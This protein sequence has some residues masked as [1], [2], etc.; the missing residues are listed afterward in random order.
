MKP[1]PIPGDVLASFDAAVLLI[2]DLTAEAVKIKDKYGSTSKL[3]ETKVAQ[4]ETI[5]TLYNKTK[6]FIE[7]AVELNK[8]LGVECLGLE[9]QLTQELYGFT[10]SQAAKFLGLKFSDEFIKMH[11][12]ID[13]IIEKLRAVK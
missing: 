2:N 13:G 12:D 6:Y 8:K 7:A 1:S 9:L 4:I 5:K 3:F 10:F 11:D